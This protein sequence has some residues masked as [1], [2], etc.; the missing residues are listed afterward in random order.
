MTKAKSRQK[1]RHSFIIGKSTPER[2]NADRTQ[3][4]T[5]GGKLDSGS[6]SR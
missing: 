4:I 1:W 5:A 2:R 3:N 6:G